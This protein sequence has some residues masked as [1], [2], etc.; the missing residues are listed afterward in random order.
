MLYHFILQQF[1]QLESYLDW[2]FDPGLVRLFANLISESD[3]CVFELYVSLGMSH[4][5]PC[6]TQPRSTLDLVTVKSAACVSK[7]GHVH[8][9]YLNHQA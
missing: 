4:Y 5:P 8:H 3:Y 9:D 6:A 2:S 7:V 1:H